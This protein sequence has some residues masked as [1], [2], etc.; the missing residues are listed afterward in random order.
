MKRY[1]VSAGLAAGAAGMQSAFA[2]AMDAGATPK[3][4]NISSNLR[5][6]YDD[7]YAVAHNKQGSFGFELSPSISANTSFATF[8]TPQTFTLSGGTYKTVQDA[9]TV[10]AW[11]QFINADTV[12]V[13]LAIAGDASVTV[14]QYVIDNIANARK[15]CVAFISPPSSAVVNQTGN[16]VANIVTW[17]NTLARTTSY[18]PFDICI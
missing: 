2:Q 3:I 4:W 9:D 17:Y 12:N 10:T 18:A 7:N 14:Q 11:G 15:D 8:A 16:E 5:G 1:F 13:S 6:F